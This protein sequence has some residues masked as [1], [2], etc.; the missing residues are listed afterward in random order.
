M[1]HRA[2]DSM[3]SSSSGEPPPRAA[4]RFRTLDDPESLREFLRNIGEGIY[5]TTPQGEI[6]DAN[7]AFLAI[8]GVPSLEAAR[9]I[10]ARDLF[11]DPKQREQEMA[12]VDRDGSVREFEIALR[13]PDG[14]LRTVL[15]TSYVIR[16]PETGERYYHGILVDITARKALEEQLVSMSL[17]DPLTGCLN[18]RVLGDVADA[19]EREP[20]VPWGAIFVD[21]DHFKRYNDEA[22]HAAG[23]EVLVRMGRFLARYVRAEEAV[24]RFG[25]DEFVVLLRGADTEHTAAVAERLR[26]AALTTAP[27]PFS[28]GWAARED[29]ESLARLIDR[30]DRGMMAVRVTDRRA[31]RRESDRS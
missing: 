1:T 21:I 14:G 31:S 25:G 22:G 26:A 6:L 16:D 12:I 27:A 7:A 4:G 18:R 23:D 20:G 3:P 2:S 8:L 24:V 10:H 19:L 11:V 9:R 5:I 13:R 28:L 15:D 30:A 17:H 29:G